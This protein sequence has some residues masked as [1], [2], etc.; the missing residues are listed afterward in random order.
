MAAKYDINYLYVYFSYDKT[1]LANGYI[2]DFYS[3]PQDGQKTQLGALINQI[4]YQNG[5]PS[6]QEVEFL[7]SFF[8]EALAKIIKQIA[9]PNNIII[10][11]IP[12]SKG[13]SDELA[14]QL[15]S[16]FNLTCANLIGKNDNLP[17]A[18]ST[19]SFNDGLENSKIKYSFNNDFIKNHRN[20]TLILR[21][22][23]T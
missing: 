10:T 21:T 8:N 14:L 20:C 4:K 2:V 5:Y 15:A 9:N 11:P 23:G 18:K 1:L 12:S 16:A 3:S 19:K 13:I 7:S 6:K 17:Q 22:H